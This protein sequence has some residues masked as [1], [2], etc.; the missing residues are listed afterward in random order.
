MKDRAE[1]L[2]GAEVNPY[3]S[4]N[5]ADAEL[6]V[7]DRADLGSVHKERPLFR[8]GVAGVVTL[9]CLP[10]LGLMAISLVPL[11]GG[12]DYT[13]DIPL[14]EAIEGANGFDWSQLPSNGYVRNAWFIPI[15]AVAGLV[16]FLVCPLR[17]AWLPAGLNALLPLYFA[18]PIGWIMVPFGGLVFASALLGSCD[19]ETWSEGYVFW[20][21]SAVWSYLWI[22]TATF[23]FFRS[24]MRS[25]RV[26][27][28]AIAT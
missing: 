6:D 2:S 10:I 18:G 19:G 3:K 7:R 24:R 1:E 13:R 22:A 26:T 4:S 5:R 20:S 21:A 17:F 11:A 23:L 25:R 14:S 15:L 8:A 9:A 16:I 27:V 12:F 28:T